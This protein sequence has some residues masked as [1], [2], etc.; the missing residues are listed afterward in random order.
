MCLCF[1]PSLS[2]ML[3]STLGQLLA[4]L[5]SQ[6]MG[7]SGSQGVGLLGQDVGIYGP[8]IEL[9]EAGRGGSESPEVALRSPPR[10]GPLEATP[11]PET[12]AEAGPARVR[13]QRNVRF[14]LRYRRLVGEY[15]RVVAESLSE[16]EEPPARAAEGGQT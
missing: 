14:P 10:E 7:G 8:D 9:T 2:Q 13:L 15:F 1:R 5:K 12:P 6:G 3:S 11:D 16:E 4:S